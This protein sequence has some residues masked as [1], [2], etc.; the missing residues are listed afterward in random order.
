MLAPWMIEKMRKDREAREQARD[1]ARPRLRIQP[2][3]PPSYYDQEQPKA[4][5]TE[6]RRGCE[7]VDFTI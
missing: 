5:E 2:P 7:I 6:N 4:T 1:D 3:P